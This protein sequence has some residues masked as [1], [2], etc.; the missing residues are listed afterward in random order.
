[1]TDERWLRHAT[2]EVH[3]RYFVR[4]SRSALGGRW[5]VGFHGQD[6]TADAFFEQLEGIPGAEDWLLASVQ[7]LNRYYTRRT[8]AIVA[9]W[10]TSQDREL[11]IADNVKWVDSALDHIEREFGAP[12]SLVFVGFSQGVAMA[13]RAGVLG[14]RECAA[15]VALNGDV[16]PELKDAT[17]R[18]WPRVLAATGSRDEWYTSERLASEAQLLRERKIDVGELVFEGGHEWTEDLAREIGRW[19]KEIAPAQM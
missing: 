7:G 16:P 1:M 19:L 10:M 9:G 14:R 13:Y 3:G 18:A 5:L 8:Q 12:R 17:N 6:Q 11:A 2:T 15:I 4:P